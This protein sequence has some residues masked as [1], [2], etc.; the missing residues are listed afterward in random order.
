MRRSILLA[1]A[2]GTAAFAAACSDQGPRP[3][4]PTAS[5]VPV[6]SALLSTQGATTKGGGKLQDIAVTTTVSDV[7]QGSAAAIASDGQGAY[8]NGASS[9]VSIL[10]TNGYNGIAYGDW[11]FDTK[12]SATRSVGHGFYAGDE[13]AVNPPL[14]TVPANP[15]YL[16]QQHFPSRLQVECTFVHKSML[17]MAAN[18]TITC[19]MLN[20]WVV[21]STVTYGLHMAPEFTGA[22]ET[23][24][25]Q[26]VCN[27]ADSVGCNDWT[28]EPLPQGAIGRLGQQVAG[29]GNNVTKTDE[30]DF[31]VR[32]LIHV[33]R[34]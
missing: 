2:L 33:T 6:S 27:A 10:T 28:L 34:P 11:Q 32:F 13:I 20:D 15:P 8:T 17:A 23:T 14:F 12:S 22:P 26:I 1:V 29:R 21:S 24:D 9:V 7:A 16:G 30:G 4:R 19:G 31:N 18:S 25:I 3:T 5:S